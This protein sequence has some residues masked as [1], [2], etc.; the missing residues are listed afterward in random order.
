MDFS[1]ASAGSDPFVDGVKT[2]EKAHLSCMIT[3][4]GFFYGLTLP[5]ADCRLPTSLN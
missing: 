2:A 5:T 1:N 3:S 4:S